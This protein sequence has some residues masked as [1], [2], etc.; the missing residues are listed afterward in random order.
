LTLK[1][2]FHRERG[3]PRKKRGGEHI[4]I[5]DRGE[6]DGIIAT[7]VGEKVVHFPI[8]AF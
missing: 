7:Q 1:R 6:G 2:D 4:E 3:K 8:F 5:G